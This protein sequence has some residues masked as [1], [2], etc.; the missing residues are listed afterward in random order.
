MGKGFDVI[1]SVPRGVS[2]SLVRRAWR[3]A[4][5]QWR[6]SRQ[7]RQL[8]RLRR[9]AVERPAGS[10]ISFDG[11]TVQVNDGYN[12]YILY[13]DIFVKRIYHFEAAR[14]NPLI[15]D[16]GS[17]I[18]MSVLYFKRIYPKA[19]IIAFEP[20]PT[21]FP[22]L[23]GNM[24]TNAV[25]GVELVR[26]GLASRSGTD[27]FYSDGRYG[28]TLAS[29]KPDDAPAWWTSC[30]VPCVRLRDY[31]TEP[32]DFVKLNIEG[33]ELE[34]LADSADRLGCIRE[35]VIEYHHLPGLPRT[36]H[37]ILALLHQRGFEY[38]ISDFDS[39]TNP[40]AGPPFRLAPDTRYYL[41][42]YAKR[43]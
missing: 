37:E 41:L 25:A 39:E 14:E 43:M 27:V 20:D 40:A 33:A 5:R 9:Q 6:Q 23:E 35:L 11:Y 31:L 3:R 13:K 34:T 38:F 28:S 2:P 22:Y 12:F 32:V 18:G 21:I 8:G 7:E 15:L 29:H 24:R 42:V 30:E 1:R 36:L 10:R 26:A 19:R 16:G 4:A 17:N